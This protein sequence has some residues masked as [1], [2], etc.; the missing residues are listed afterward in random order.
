MP[1]RK[2]DSVT[3]NGKRQS[4]PQVRQKGLPNQQ[5]EVVGAA[6]AP[7]ETG[8]VKFGRGDGAERKYPTAKS[9]I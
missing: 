8:G 3:I 2:L 6:P 1:N 5:P 7:A 4:A 9:N